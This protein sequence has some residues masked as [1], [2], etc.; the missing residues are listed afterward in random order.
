MRDAVDMLLEGWASP[1]NKKM[2]KP[3]EPVIVEPVVVNLIPESRTPAMLDCGHTDWF[4]D[5]ANDAARRADYC[6]AGAKA[7]HALDW[8][9]R[10]LLYPVPLRMR[11]GYALT[12]SGFQGLC[13]DPNGY[14]IG[15][16]GND[17]R[18]YSNGTA[19]CPEHD[20]EKEAE[21][22]ATR[23]HTSL[24]RSEDAASSRDG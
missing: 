1:K 18:Y 13:C 15:G 9:V 21:P 19:R 22:Q 24:R 20:R 16:N 7:S 6:C 3:V 2:P 14:Y 11:R 5:E 4:G 10:G 17:C 23:G 12:S 8:R